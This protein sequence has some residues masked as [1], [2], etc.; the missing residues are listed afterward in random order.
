MNPRLF[1]IAALLS[2][3][4]CS[5]ADEMEERI[6]PSGEANAAAATPLPPGS[7]AGDARAIAE[8]TEDFEFEYSWPGEANAIPALAR[9]LQGRADTARAELVETTR[10]DRATAAEADY[11]FRPHSFSGEW[12][13]VADLP[14]WLSL[15]STI[16]TY[17][18]GAHP[19]TGFDSLL[20][21]KR[22]GVAR[23]PLA[24]FRDPQNFQNAIARRF[25]TMLD[26][27]R[28]ER[29]GEPV[30]PDADDYFSACPGVEEIT[31]LL[32]S[33]DGETFDRVGIL[34]MPYVAGPYAEGSYE[35]DLPVDTA[36]LDA[37]K[38][39]YERAF[40]LGPQ[41]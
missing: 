38:P 29:R 1:L 5:D 15:S 30:D 41:N 7:A 27:E 2:S 25:C 3:A 20:W 24:L 37:V 8:S 4:A 11:P 17:A 31:V 33:S 26:A 23:D 19:N 40:S 28:G 16:S 9:L 21:D 22:A 32:G 39:G 35:F 36:L 12:Q 13:L 10:E 34:V 14:G 6:G 18:G